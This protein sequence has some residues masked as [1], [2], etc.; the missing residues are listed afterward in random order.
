MSVKMWRADFEQLRPV[1]VDCPKGGWPESDAEGHKI[2]LNSHFETE[3]AAW[4]RLFGEVKAAIA[5]AGVNV[6]Q[7]EKDLLEAHRRAGEHAKQFSKLRD[8]FGRRASTMG[9]DQD[10]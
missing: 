6:I 9:A 7:A 1:C 3:E 4:G 10:D 5:L 8:N 2:Y